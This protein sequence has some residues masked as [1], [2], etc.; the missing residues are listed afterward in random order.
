[1][2]SSKTGCGSEKYRYASI[3]ELWLV[4]DT[5]Y[6]GSVYELLL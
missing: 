3:K 5:H 1:M 2:V 6:L 4:P